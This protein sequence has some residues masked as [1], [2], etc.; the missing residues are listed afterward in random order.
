MSTK[1]LNVST[2]CDDRDRQGILSKVEFV[3]LVLSPFNKVVLPH[4]HKS[5]SQS[6]AGLAKP[7]EWLFS[8]LLSGY[9]VVEMQL[10]S[11]ILDGDGKYQPVVVFRLP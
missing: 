2:T 5:F 3:W 7:L 1:P 8:G 10:T 9:C 6:A 4:G 11:S